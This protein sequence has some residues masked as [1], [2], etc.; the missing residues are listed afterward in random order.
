[1][2]M[3]TESAPER[4]VRAVQAFIMLIK[5]TL[6][7][8]CSTRMDAQCVRSYRLCDDTG[9]DAVHSVGQNRPT[10]KLYSIELRPFPG[11]HIVLDAGP[12]LGTNMPRHAARDERVIFTT[13]IFE[14]ELW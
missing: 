4:C 14:F 6:T 7:C 9:D 13:L 3:T 8:V 2:Q 10:V 5:R 11:T 1:M 12:I